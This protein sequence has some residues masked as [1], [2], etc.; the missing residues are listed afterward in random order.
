MPLNQVARKR[1]T[2]SKSRGS[3]Q[4]PDHPRVESDG[5]MAL[6]LQTHPFVL[7]FGVVE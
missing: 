4:G 6:A 1:G 2:G 7:R 5:P 3:T